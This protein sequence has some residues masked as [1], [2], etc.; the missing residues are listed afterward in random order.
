MSI[1][2]LRFLARVRKWD[3]HVHEIL[4][5]NCEQGYWELNTQMFCSS[6]SYFTIMRLLWTKGKLFMSL[7]LLAWDMIFNNSSY[8]Y[9][10]QR[11][12]NSNTIVNKGLKKKSSRNIHLEWSL[13][14]DIKLWKWFGRRQGRRN[15]LFIDWFFSYSESLA[16]GID[17]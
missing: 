1:F 15:C 6:R 17:A 11:K 5:K 9:R 2:N 7:F 16:N 14:S 8:L 4:P 13:Y 12:K 3:K 10:R